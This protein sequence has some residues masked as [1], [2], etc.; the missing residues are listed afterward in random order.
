MSVS[1]SLPHVILE[2]DEREN[3]NN[4]NKIWFI[5]PTNL[6]DGNHYGSTEEMALVLSLS[7]RAVDFI[8]NF[9]THPIMFSL[10]KGPFWFQTSK[11]EDLTNME[12]SVSDCYV[13]N[14]KRR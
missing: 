3:N 8:L 10:S 12:E 5:L 1:S 7:P 11:H 4:N 6:R 9:W 14:E 13:L 2:R